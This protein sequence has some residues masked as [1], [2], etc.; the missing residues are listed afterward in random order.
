[1]ALVLQALNDHDTMS[2]VK[3]VSVCVGGGG[4]RGGGGGSSSC[5]SLDVHHALTARPCAESAVVL[6][7]CGWVEYLP[8]LPLK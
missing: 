7:C 4:W 2:F 5:C 6:G 3:L 1:M 8:Y